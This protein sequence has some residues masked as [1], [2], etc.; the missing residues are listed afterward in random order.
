MKMNILKVILSIYF[1][2]IITVTDSSSYGPTIADVDISNDTSTQ[3]T[4]VATHGITVSSYGASSDSSEGTTQGN[5]TNIPYITDTTENPNHSSITT[6]VRTSG[7]PKTSNP[8]AV[9]ETSNPS[10]VPD[11]TTI[12]VPSTSSNPTTTHGHSS[13]DGSGFNGLS[14]GI[15]ILAGVIATFLSILLVFLYRR[16]H[17][18][19]T[20]SNLDSTASIN[21]LKD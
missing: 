8:S 1:S 5:S 4:Q 13:G 15:G 18:Y 9:P 21:F 19:E 14:F 7:A 17:P 3:S 16:R 20:L 12:T 2:G 10:T 6:A 11:K